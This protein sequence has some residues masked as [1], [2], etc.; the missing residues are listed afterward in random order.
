MMNRMEMMK[1]ELRMRR[2]RERKVGR[3]K[4]GRKE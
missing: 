2:E 1:D 4:K 3:K